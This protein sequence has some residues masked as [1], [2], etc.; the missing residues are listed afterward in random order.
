MMQAENLTKANV[1]KLE[2]AFKGI[3]KDN[4][5]AVFRTFVNRKFERKD[6][7]FRDRCKK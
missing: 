3:K 6:C 5:E 1:D 7:L 2:K 4:P